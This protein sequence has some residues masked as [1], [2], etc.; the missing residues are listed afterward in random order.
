MTHSAI[1]KEL[2]YDYLGVIAA[3]SALAI[4]VGLQRTELAV[5]GNM[6]V[7]SDWITSDNIGQ[8][9]GL[10]LAGYLA[11]CVH[12]TRLK[13]EDQ[14]LRMIRIALIVCIVT[15]FIEPLFPS[16]GWN[17]IWRLVSGWG[18]A[19]LV[20]GLPGFGTRR[21]HADQKRLAMGIIFAGAGI[22]PLLD[23]VLLPF[24]VK[25]SPVAAWDFTGI[26]SILFA[27]P[28]WMLI[29]RGLSE[30]RDLKLSHSSAQGIPSSS[31]QENISAKSTAPSTINWTPALKIFAL[32]TLLYGASQVSILTYQPL[33]LTSVFKVSSEVASSSFALVGFGYT[34]GAVVAGLVPKKIPTDSVLLA[35]VV[36]GTIGTCIFV[37]SPIIAVVNLGAFLFAFWNG[38]YIGLIVARLSEV[39]GP[40]LVRPAWALF[41]FL[42]S[43]GFVAMTFIAG[44]ISTFSVTMIF[45][46][47]L[48][49]VVINLILMSL[50]A[51]AFKKQNI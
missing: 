32:T 12:Q 34:L 6:M 25:S 47:G 50:T 49:L 26:F 11:G 18:C 19:H 13:R 27:V 3:S 9:V 40:R 39:V 15:F 41:S 37:F 48:A 51:T 8:L 23:S 7:E 33:Y 5:L 45:Y 28:I 42:L 46:I 44:F 22:A 35:S 31:T 16:M 21:L 43:I 36:I 1:N 30:E 20:T 14:S 10:N 4:G 38:A 2:S 29:S 17:A 24:F